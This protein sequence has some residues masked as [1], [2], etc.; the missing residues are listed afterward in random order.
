MSTTSTSTTSTAA[1]TAPGAPAPSSKWQHVGLIVELC[2]GGAFLA[3]TV[4]SI[5]HYA[6]AVFFVGGTAAFFVGRKLHNS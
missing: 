3:G 1:S 4:L 6:I 5:H 2:G